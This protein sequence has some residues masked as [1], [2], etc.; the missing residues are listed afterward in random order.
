MGR[1]PLLPGVLELAEQGVL[2]GGI[3]RNRESCE[4]A[5][6]AGEGVEAGDA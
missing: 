3:E 1:V 2:P 6:E 5:V 4:A